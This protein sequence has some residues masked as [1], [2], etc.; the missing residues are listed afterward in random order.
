MIIT[1]ETTCFVPS[2]NLVSLFHFSLALTDDTSHDSFYRL[3]VVTRLLGTV[4]QLGVTIGLLLSQ[5]LGLS[6]ILGTKEGWPFLLGVSFIPA[7]L[8]LCLLPMCPE[9]PRYLLIS[10]GRTSEARNGKRDLSPNMSRVARTRVEV[11]RAQT[12]MRLAADLT[13]LSSCSPRR[14]LTHYLPSSYSSSWSSRAIVASSRNHL[15]GSTSSFCA[16]LSCSAQLPL[17]LASPSPRF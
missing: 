9:S 7:V 8:Q 17:V 1:I 11:C 13:R 16:S 14:H 15:L 12:A 6:P 2:L 5:V 3:S 10:K 4:S